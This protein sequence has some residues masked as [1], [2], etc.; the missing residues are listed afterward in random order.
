M[1]DVV[2]LAAML[3]NSRIQMVLRYAHATE[4]HQFAVMEKTQ[5][6]LAKEAIPQRKS[7][8]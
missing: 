4:E 7:G 2:T 1:R 6:Y 3:G 8:K 5:G